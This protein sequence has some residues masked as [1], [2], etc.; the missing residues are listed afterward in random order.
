MSGE[1]EAPAPVVP[2]EFGAAEMPGLTVQR[3]VHFDRLLKQTAPLP[4]LKTAVIAPE[5][6][7]ALGGALL[8]AEHTLIDPI[9][10]GDAALIREAADEIGKDVSCYPIIDVPGH[11]AAIAYV[12][13]MIRSG[14]AAAVM[15][16][17]LH[18]STLLSEVV[19]RDCGLRGRRLISHVFV[20]DVPGLEYLLLVTD[21]A[22]H[23]GHSFVNDTF[24]IP[25]RFYDEGVRRYGFRGLS[26]DYPT[27]RLRED[28]P[29]LAA[30]RV[31]IAHRGNGASMCA[32]RNGRSVASTM[33]FTA[34][35]GLPM[36]TR[37]G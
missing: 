37:S 12:V 1:A 2:I 25:R 17:H 22:F 26:Y 15:K 5:E 4:A 14:E 13:F 36:G 24:A 21:A 8:A 16:G 6:A 32:V 3:H 19:R 9:L 31:V 35:D 23:Y 10:I 7:E 29:H 28:W 20:M 18:T 27:G 11:R 34:L 33:G 30:G